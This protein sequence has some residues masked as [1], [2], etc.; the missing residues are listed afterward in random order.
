MPE[1]V[2]KLVLTQPGGQVQEFVLSGGGATLGR[3]TV[4]D[5]VLNVKTV[6]SCAF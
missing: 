2:P 5:I 6:A 3:G 4:N 1:T